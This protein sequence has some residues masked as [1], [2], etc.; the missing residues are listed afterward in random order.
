MVE[1]SYE[2]EGRKSLETCPLALSC[3]DV[4]GSALPS[5][6]YYTRLILL[7]QKLR[8]TLLFLGCV[9]Q[10]MGYSKGKVSKKNSY[11]A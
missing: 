9:C 6:P 2:S 3:S 8:Q 4:N 7:N 1:G 11:Q 5:P 10:V